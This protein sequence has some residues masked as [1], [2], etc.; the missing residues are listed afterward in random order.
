MPSFPAAVQQ[1]VT[2]GPVA[3]VVVTIV[4]DVCNTAHTQGGDDA[5]GT[6][7]TCSANHHT[8]M[9]VAGVLCTW[10]KMSARKTVPSTC[11]EVGFEATTNLFCGCVRV[12][13]KQRPTVQW[14]QRAEAVYATA[15]HQHGR[16]KVHAQSLQA[17]TLRSDNEPRHMPQN[18]GQPHTEKGCM[19]VR[20]ELDA[21]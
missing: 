7:R 2:T 10:S 9:L 4:T 8:W 20:L 12:C 5:A 1:V 21:I 17:G 16:R 19:P 18:S 14:V 13:Y 6:V 11:T 3:S 15:A